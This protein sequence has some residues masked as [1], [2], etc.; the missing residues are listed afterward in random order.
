MAGIIRQQTDAEKDMTPSTDGNTTGF[1]SIAGNKQTAETIFK[2]QL[3][4]QEQKATKEHKPFARQVAIEDFDEHYRAEAQKSMR[5][6]GFVK[7][8]EIKSLKLDWTKYSDLKNFKEIITKEVPD[9]GLT[10]RYG[11]PIYIKAIKYKFKGF[12][13]FTYTVMEDSMDAVNRVLTK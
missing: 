4:E 5:K 9:A 3:I 6:N 10:K 7:A 1:I 8:E 2:K 12:E 11:K 13:R